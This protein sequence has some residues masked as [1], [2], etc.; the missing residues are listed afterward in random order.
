VTLTFDLLTLKVMF[1][2]GVTW[3]TCMQ[4]LVFPGIS[5]LNLGPMYE[6]DVRR[7]QTHIIA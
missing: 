5:V 1:Q 3:A 2:S 6:T 7:H 4:I